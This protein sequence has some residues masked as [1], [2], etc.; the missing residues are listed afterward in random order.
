MPCECCE[1]G[2][3]CQNGNCIAG[4]TASYCATGPGGFG[5]GIFTA[6]SSDCA[7]YT[8]TAGPPYDMA[9]SL[10]N[11]CQCINVPGRILRPPYTTCNCSTLTSAGVPYGGCAAYS[12]LEC[13]TGTGNCV[14]TCPSPRSCCAGT[15]CPLPQRCDTASGTCVDKCT[16]GTF[17]AGTGSAYAC[18]TSGQKCCGPSGCLARSTVSG[19][20]LLAVDKSPGTGGWFD[21][22]TDM[23]AG[24]ML[25]VSA[26]G[27]VGTATPNGKSTDCSNSSRFS[28][29]F[30]YMALL[31]RVGPSGTT[32]LLGSSYTGLT[33]AG[34]LYMR[35]NR[36][37]F[38]SGVSAG[39]F[40]ISYSRGADPCPGYTPAAIGEPIVYAAG[41][42]PPKPLPGPGAALKSLL[43]LVGIVA[44][45]TC[46]CNA[47][48]AQM[49][50]WGEWECLKRLPEICGWLKEEAKKRELW[51]FPP[52]G[53]ALIL[54]SISLSALKRLLR[55]N[56]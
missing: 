34:R 4:V 12:C 40:S 36:T 45:P 54:A 46:S 1:T 32:F 6:G 56:S 33:G 35:V 38:I 19:T 15:C 21:T 39:D 18:C 44:S 30:C 31:G 41:E 16:T 27:T 25:T 9:C 3:C 5:P 48:A 20:A 37:D 14:Y 28:T 42:E 23:L 51:F 17:C 8:C 7:Q 50:V 29:A 43:R 22:G 24:D 26:S 10:V 53:A 55:G 47:R 49:D 11:A 52:A 2:R 13:D